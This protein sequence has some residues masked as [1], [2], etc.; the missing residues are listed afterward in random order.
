MDAGFRRSDFLW[1]DLVVGG[2]L[3]GSAELSEAFG[4]SKA[5]VY[6]VADP[7]EDEGPSVA[8]ALAGVDPANVKSERGPLTLNYVVTVLTRDVEQKSALSAAVYDTLHGY[9]GTMEG[10]GWPPTPPGLP[11]G[12]FAD[13]SD[14]MTLDGYYR[15]DMT[16]LIKV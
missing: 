11:P 9:S 10:Y 15:R 8:Y 12:S 14:V 5:R 16:F 1:A 2:L 3:Q 7:A 4:A 13:A 6:N